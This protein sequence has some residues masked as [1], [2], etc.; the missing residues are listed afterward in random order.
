MI[1]FPIFVSDGINISQNSCQVY[2]K[3]LYEGV[4]MID[5]SKESLCVSRI[6]D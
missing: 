6:G 3:D 1:T 2:R 4:I 5:E